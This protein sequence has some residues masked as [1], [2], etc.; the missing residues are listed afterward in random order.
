MK[1][2]DEIKKAEER[3]EKM[4]KEAEIEGQKIIEQERESARRSIAALDEERE[5]VTVAKLKQARD[6]AEKEIKKLQ[7]EHDENIKHI[8]H[9]YKKNKDKAIKKVH[10]I[11]IKWPS[12]R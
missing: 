9:A 10:E 12:S 8:E 2:I 4:K 1:L 7:K 6:A 5:K 11:I 3:A